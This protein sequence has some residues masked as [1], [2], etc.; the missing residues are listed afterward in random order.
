MITVEQREDGR[1]QVFDRC[2]GFLFELGGLFLPLDVAV[3]NDGDIY[4][5]SDIVDNDDKHVSVFRGQ[6]PTE[7]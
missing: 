6:T 7:Q 3:N 4:I 1:I 2:G 5:V